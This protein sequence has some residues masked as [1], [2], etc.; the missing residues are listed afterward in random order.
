MQTAAY[1]V[2]AFIDCDICSASEEDVGTSEP[3]HPGADDGDIGDSAQCLSKG[4]H[5]HCGGVAMSEGVV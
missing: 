2:P 5:L 3:G 4:L 1:A